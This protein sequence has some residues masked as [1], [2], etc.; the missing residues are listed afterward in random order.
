MVRGGASSV[1]F[2]L[3][4]LPA[5]LCSIVL[6]RQSTTTLPATMAT[7][8]TAAATTATTAQSLVSAKCPDSRDASGSSSGGSGSNVVVPVAA[9]DRFVTRRSGDGWEV[10][11]RRSVLHEDAAKLGPSPS[12]HWHEYKAVGRGSEL[13]PVFMCLYPPDE[14]RWVSGLIR[15][16]GR[17]PNCDTLTDR[18]LR[19][20][21]A[22]NETS[23]NDDEGAGTVFVDVGAN[24]GACVVQILATTHAR[25]IAFEPSPKNLFRLTSTLL[26][27]PEEMKNRVTLFPVALGAE[28][29]SAT[30]WANPSNAGNTQVVQSSKGGG[31]EATKG[32]AVS[33]ATVATHNIPVEGMDDL[34]AKDLRV[35]LL[36]MDV[37]GFECFVLSGMDRVLANTHQIFFEVEEELLGRFKGSPSTSSEK[38]CSGARLV[39]TIQRAGFR[40][41]NIVDLRSHSDSD[42]QNITFD[43][44]DMYGVRQS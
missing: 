17:W 13:P 27:L 6:L 35:D 14:D 9:A 18:L 40:V 22:K 15:K 7:R 42:L 43:D 26:N 8:T 16:N 33:G 41:N 24:I 44:Q 31:E 38:S 1:M 30:I 34:L 32:E 23:D 39:R 5:M 10:W 20:N 25:I 36:K 21:R 29:A 11:D 2:A 28:S 19:R 3:L 12:C 37:Q 4:G